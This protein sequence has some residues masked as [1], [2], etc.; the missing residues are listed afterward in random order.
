MQHRMKTH[1][2]TPEQVDTLLYKA[3]VG[4]LGT[5]SGDGYPYVISMH[6]IYHD[7][8]IYMHGLPKGQKIDNINRNSK[9]CFEIDE[10]FGLL[11]EN[12]TIACDTEAEY[13]SVIIVGTATI[14]KD[15]EL[16]RKVLDKI[17]EKFTP[18]FAGHELPE[19]MVK[20][21][22]VIEIQIERCTGKYHK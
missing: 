7:G 6:F 10:L 18:Q 17:V 2:L 13:N 22:A 3:E 4:R 20:G 12:V 19:K 5:I 9:V 11:T 21:T 15:I 14:V 8:K 1:Q 16:K